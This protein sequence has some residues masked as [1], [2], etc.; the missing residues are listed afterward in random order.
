MKPDLAEIQNEFRSVIDKGLRI[1]NMLTQLGL[2][3]VVL[4]A[5]STLLESELRSKISQG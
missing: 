5:A 4:E 3:E 2:R 1:T